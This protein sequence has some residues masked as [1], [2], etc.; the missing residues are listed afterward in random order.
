MIKEVATSRILLAKSIRSWIRHNPHRHEL[1]LKFSVLDWET[2]AD[3]LSPE[4][5]SIELAAKPPKDPVGTVVRTRFG[6]VIIVT[7]R[8]MTKRAAGKME[9]KWVMEDDHSRVGWMKVP[10]YN[11]DFFRTYPFV[12]M[13]TPKEMKGAREGYLENIEKKYE[14]IKQNRQAIETQ[15]IK[16]GDIVSVKYSNGTQKEVVLEVDYRTGKLA[17]VRRFGA[18]YTSKRRMLPT[19][20]CTK[21]IDGGGTFNPT[22]PLYEKQGMRIPDFYKRGGIVAPRQPKRFIW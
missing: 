20:I 21:L 16:P 10:T 6:N 1:K 3:A 5:A 19:N 12:R 11:F 4:T 18:D 17:I 8:Y 22:N 7:S 9:Y 13:A 2:I 14:S 15:E